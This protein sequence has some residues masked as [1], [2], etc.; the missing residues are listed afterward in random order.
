[1]LSKLFNWLGSFNDP[2]TKRNLEYRADYYFNRIFFKRVISFYDDINYH[3]STNSIKTSTA[4]FNPLPKIQFGDSIKSV[5]GLLG[6]HKFSYSNHSTENLIQVLFYRIAI[7]TFYS[8][9]QL[10]FHNDK[11]YFIGI[12]NAKSMPSEKEKL[13]ILNSIMKA[14]LPTSLN[15]I[16]DYK[17]IQDAN[18]HFIYLNDEINFSI[19]FLDKQYLNNR[20]QLSL[21]LNS[22]SQ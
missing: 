3:I 19:C 16:S 6:K 9:V 22:T 5:Q 21:A 12:D 20:E 1:M 8:F 14:Q 10:Q 18:G 17:T 15:K 11:L 7:E 2:N 4:E 13:L